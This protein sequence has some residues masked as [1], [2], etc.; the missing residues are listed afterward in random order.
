MASALM[1]VGGAIVNGLA[2]S[3]SNYL[4]S[5]LS[6]HDE[7]EKHYKEMQR[8]QAEKDAYEKKRLA[9]L[10]FINQRLTNQRHAEQTFTDVDQ[11]MKEY[12]RITGDK[13]YL[14]SKP[15]ESDYLSEDKKTQEILFIILGTAAVYFFATKL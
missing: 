7:S 12:Y 4:F 15:K 14:P 10:D 2:F 1:F 8:L 9:M 13:L 6:K 5:K 11:A 3:G